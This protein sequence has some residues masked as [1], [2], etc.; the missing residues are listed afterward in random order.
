MGDPSDPKNSDLPQKAATTV[1]GMIKEGPG[2][3]AGDNFDEKKVKA[4]LLKFPNDLTAD[5]VYDRLIWLFAEDYE[6]IVKEADALKPQFTIS[7]LGDYDP[8][9]QEPAELLKPRDEKKPTQIAIVIDASGSMA[10]KVNGKVKMDE[11]QRAVREFASSLPEQTKVSLRVYGHLGSNQ[12]KDKAIS[13]AS[14]E[15]I[16]ALSKYESNSFESA[17]NQLRPVGWTP[18]AAAIRGAGEDLR[19]DHIGANN[20]VYVVSDGLETCGGDPVKEAQALH[21][22]DVKAVVNIIGFDL[23]AK[24]KQVLEEV[25]KAGGGSF[26]SANSSD[27]IRKQMKPKFDIWRSNDITHWKLRNLSSLHEQEEEHRK[28]IYK[29]TH[30]F[31]NH[32]ESKFLVAR[33]REK[34]RIKW[35]L[36][37]LGE[38]QKISKEFASEFGEVYKKAQNRFILLDEYRDQL[39]SRKIEEME[40]E[41]RKLYDKVLEIEK[42]EKQKVYDLKN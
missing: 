11:A 28:K 32:G 16:Y 30:W 27:E 5:E 3:F 23:D 15:E 29:L 21:Q 14:T 33:E 12:E 8:N 7:K 1:D 6:A 10:G 31:T 38:N 22:S 35:A 39:Q 42:I 20:I 13:C 19:K 26:T 25:A 40:K 18:L 24:S 34:E 17:V 36:Q 4:E 41:K 2:K 37:F 9:T